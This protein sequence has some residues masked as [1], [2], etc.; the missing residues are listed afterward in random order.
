MDERRIQRAGF[1]YYLG[2]ALQS[3]IFAG[4]LYA[5]VSGF[6]QDFPW[7][8]VAIITFLIFLFQTVWKMRQLEQYALSMATNVKLS[9]VREKEIG[10]FTK[11]S[12]LQS[13]K[14]ETVKHREAYFAA[15]VFRNEL[16]NPTERNHAN[17]VWAT[18]TYYDKKK[19]LLIDPIDGRWSGSDHPKSPRDI[20]GLLRRRI[21][22]DGSNETLDVAIKPYGQEKWYAYNNNN[23]FFDNMVDDSHLLISSEV[24]V[25]ITLSGER[26]KKSFWIRIKNIHNGGIQAKKLNWLTKWL[27]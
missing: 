17:N 5:D 16:K 25:R 1:F 19:M 14:G 10:V 8:Y 12:I 11:G 3:F 21:R 2:I 22:S 7:Q 4:S 9:H 15:V 6:A 27:P 18:L 26:V 13:P 23:C 20:Q 24:N